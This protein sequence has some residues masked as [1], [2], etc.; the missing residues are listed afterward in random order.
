[1]Q[2][3]EMKIVRGEEKNTFQGEGWLRD[4][5]AFEIRE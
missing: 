1:V 5:G 3:K 4:K 2:G